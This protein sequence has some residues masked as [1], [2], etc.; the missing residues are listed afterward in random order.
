MTLE[1]RVR[2]A[3]QMTQGTLPL[4][5][6]VPDPATQTR[7]IAITAAHRHRDLVEVLTESEYGIKLRARPLARPLERRLA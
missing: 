2:S 4:W 7:A 3:L 6:V 5:I 1:E